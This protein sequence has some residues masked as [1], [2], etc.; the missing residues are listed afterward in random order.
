[1]G[2]LIGPVIQLIV[3]IAVELI[4]ELLLETGLQCAARALRSRAGRFT[5][6]GLAGLAFGVGWGVHLSGSP[7][8]PRLLW[9]SLA[10]AV[11]GVLLAAGRAGAPVLA[12]P[13]GR[14][15]GGPRLSL[16]GSGPRSGSSASRS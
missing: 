7:A 14:A 9:V 11:A 3:Y 12:A 16:P 6:A 5:V 13:A 8:W 4:G 2:F 15:R 10:L 1:M